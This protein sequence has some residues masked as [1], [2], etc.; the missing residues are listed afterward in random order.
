MQGRFQFGLIREGL[1]LN[2]EA[3]TGAWEKQNLPPWLCPQCT[4][5]L[6]T[7]EEEDYSSLVMAQKND[8]NRVEGRS[9]RRID[10]SAVINITN[11]AQLLY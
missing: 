5:S 4:T 7:S 9:G 11:T 2:R 10:Y 6:L 8:A 1:E 3:L